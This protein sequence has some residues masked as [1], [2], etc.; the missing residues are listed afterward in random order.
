MSHPAQA[1]HSES[2]GAHAERARLNEVVQHLREHLGDSLIA[3]VLF[4]SQARGEA[5]PESDWAC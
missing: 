2:E 3:V 4:G 5:T 1:L